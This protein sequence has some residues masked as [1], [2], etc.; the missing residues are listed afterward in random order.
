MCFSSDLIR[1]SMATTFSSSG[2]Y[3]GSL[4][5]MPMG[6][7]T[8]VGNG[9]PDTQKDTSY[10]KLMGHHRDKRFQLCLPLPPREMGARS[11]AFWE[12]RP[13]GF[14][15]W[16]A[17]L[18]TKAGDVESNPGPT[19]TYKQVWICDI[20]NKQIYYRKYPKYY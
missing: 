15:G 6:S 20:C 3:R 8:K 19:T 2:L 1:W 14:A 17:L 18:L 7:T 13:C 4:I 16:Q 11:I 9:T 5:P 12:G 10:K